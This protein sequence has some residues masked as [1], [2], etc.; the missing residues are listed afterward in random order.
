MG[1]LKTQRY[2]RV[3]SRKAPAVRAAN[4]YRQS[5]VADAAD[6]FAAAGTAGSRLAGRSGGGSGDLSFC[7]F[8]TSLLRTSG[9][10]AYR[11]IDVR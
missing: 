1:R 2:S 5:D 10:M 4:W 9:R 6:P 11:T 8:I 7:G 3:A